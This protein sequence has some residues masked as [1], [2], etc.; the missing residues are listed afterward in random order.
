MEGKNIQESKTSSEEAWYMIQ[1][2]G[3]GAI[4]LEESQAK[5]TGDNSK[6]NKGRKQFGTREANATY[7]QAISKVSNL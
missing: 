6:R 7:P 3:T 4:L 1:S 2:I 5:K